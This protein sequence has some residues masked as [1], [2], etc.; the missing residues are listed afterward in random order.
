[1]CP[2]PEGGL[3]CNRI[4]VCGPRCTVIAAQKQRWIL[5]E[6]PSWAREVSVKRLEHGMTR[7]NGRPEG[8]AVSVAPPGADSTRSGVRS[9]GRSFTGAERDRDWSSRRLDRN[10]ESDSCLRNDGTSILVWRLD[11]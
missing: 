7:A 9:I 5:P 10:G 4:C 1:M 3:V 11:T 2:R 6:R 8:H